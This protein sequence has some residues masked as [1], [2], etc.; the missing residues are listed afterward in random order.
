MPQKIT[1]KARNNEAENIVL[2]FNPQ[3]IS[4]TQTA[5]WTYHLGH[6]GSN[7]LPKV[8]FSGIQP[9]QLTLSNCLFDTEKMKE[10]TSVMKHIDIIHKGMEK[11]NNTTDFLRP[12]IYTFKWGE[13]FYFDCVME[14]LSCKLTKFLSDG[15]PVRAFVDLTLLEVDSA[16]VSP[17]I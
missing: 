14:N 17:E 8:N 9:R 16:S 10:K 5:K 2:M 15:T 11:S 6:R 1:L 7:L 4:F 13:H 12:P 3:E